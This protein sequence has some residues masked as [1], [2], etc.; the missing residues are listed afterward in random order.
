M[1]FFKVKQFMKM[2]TQHIILPSVYNFYRRKTVSKKLVIFADAHHNT[3]PPSMRY[4]YEKIKA[5]GYTVLEFFLD[6]GNSSVI[7]IIKHMI[8][9]MKAYAQA[10]CVFLCDYYLPASSCEKK[11]ETVLVQL[12]H[13]CG[14]YKKF[15]YDAK[16]DIPNMYKGKL[17]KNCDLVTVSASYCVPIYTNAMRVPEGVV[18]ATGI[19]RTDIF[20][21]VNYQKENK[22]QFYEE[23]PQAKGKKLLLW[24]PTFRG[25]AANPIV[26]GLD[27]IL[28]VQEFYKNE[29]YIIIKVH[30]HV[31]AKQK[32]SNCTMDTE[33]LLS[34]IDLLV[35][36]YSSIL[37]DYL[38]FEKP[39]LLFAED[40]GKYESERGFY[41]DINSFPGKILTTEIE[42]IQAINQNFSE[43]YRKELKFCR[44]YHMGSCDGMATERII[45]WIREKY[46][47]NIN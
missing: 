37:F 3:L 17:F 28:K 29:W 14:A 1:L 35:T 42:L 30:P 20:Y 6:F 4:M 21:D 23:Y 39:F 18:N 34:F 24:A 40:F 5:D 47:N 10:G 2:V 27:T 45:K 25:N 31:E 19:S 38:L 43:E 32:I 33:N 44:E 12:W 9:F 22:K 26:Y 13:A 11:A 46:L 7:Q 8:S 15:G 41:L 16:D 36:D